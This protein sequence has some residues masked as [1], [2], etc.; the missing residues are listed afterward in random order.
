MLGDMLQ[1]IMLLKI[2]DKLKDFLI[3]KALQANQEVDEI[4]RAHV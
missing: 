1:N 3:E 2:P 4:G